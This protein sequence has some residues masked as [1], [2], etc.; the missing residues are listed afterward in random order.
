MPFHARLRERHRHGRIGLGLHGCR[1]NRTCN[2]PAALGAGLLVRLQLLTAR[3]AKHGFLLEA[4]ANGRCHILSLRNRYT[5]CSR[6][7]AANRCLR[8]SKLRQS[9][10]FGSP[11]RNNMKLGHYHRPVALLN[12]VPS[13]VEETS[14]IV[15]EWPRLL[16]LLAGY[17]HSAAR[18]SMDPGPAAFQRS[19][20]A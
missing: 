20:L 12:P 8:P 3:G 17:S 9:G 5:A 2:R 15:L 13:P 1:R 4:S 6:E 18:S 16:E 14:G 11:N 19:G 10:R 7:R